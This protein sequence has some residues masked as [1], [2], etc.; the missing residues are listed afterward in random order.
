MPEP[1]V[2]LRGFS[3]RYPGAR[4]EALDRIDL[5]VSEGEFCVLA[6]RSAGGKSTLLRALSGLVPHFHGG[7]VAGE[8]RIC[9]LDLREAGPAELGARVGF[10]AQEPEAQVISAT[11]RAEIELP[12]ETSGQGP[13]ARARAVEEVA[14]ALG[15]EGLL[16]RPTAS[17]SGGELQRVALAAA[18]AARPALVLLDE[19]TSQL[20]PVAGDELIG[21]LR[22]LN[23]E[24]GTTVV[25]A[26][27]RLERCLASADRVIAIDSGRIGFDGS[28]GGFGD[29]S[30]D[31]DPALATPVARTFALAGVRPVPIAVKQAR[32]ELRSRSLSF[33]A[34]TERGA[35]PDRRRWRLPGR[36]PRAATAAL[37][38]R[39]LWVSLDDG[40]GPIDVLR[41][42]SLRLEPGERVALMGRNGAGKSTFLRTLAG[43]QPA[44]RGRTSTPAGCAFVP[45]RPG[46]LL[47]AERVGDDLPGAA[48]LE[49]LRRVGLED[50]ADSDPRDL[51]GGQRQRLALAI[52]MAGRGEPGTAPG[53]ICLDEPTR[54]MDRARK[55]E[56]GA[57][58]DRLT[59]A[60]SAILVATHDVEFAA[61]AVDRV[62]ILG[63]GEL[64]A[65][66]PAD[67]VLAGGWYFST[68]V[69]RALGAP[70][71]TTV[72]AGAAALAAL[73]GPVAGNVTDARRAE[74]ARRGEEPA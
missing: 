10:V 14:L 40:G 20:D 49:A 59:A 32:R 31:A 26:E 39:D 53:L 58:L 70:G 8:A 65:D 42:V 28:P 34:A 54:G 41:G 12:L 2:D 38:V 50:A 67:E 48:G 37:D 72:A 66:G 18:L 22:R 45:Q 71:A 23:E 25:L 27:H 61:E 3:Y 64:L 51:S 68:E 1:L 16:A 43:V 17:L 69:A 19:P 46:D 52:A 60:G 74:L 5:E 11:P 44:L 35:Q 57:W 62:V 13:A 33:E 21:V 29:W 36:G 56:L 9:G 55:S 24:W 47:L 6:G 7:D 73:L 63:G 4:A 30:V 15:I